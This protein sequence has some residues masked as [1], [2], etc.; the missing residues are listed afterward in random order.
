[1]KTILAPTDFSEISTN[2]VEY[3]V[4]LAKATKAKLILF[5]AYHTPPVALELPIPDMTLAQIEK[6][7]LKRLKDI[8]RGIHQKHGSDLPIHVECSCGFAVDQIHNCIEKHQVDL[9]VLGIDGSSNFMERFI[10]S[11]TT[12][13]MREATC[14]V[15]G[16]SEHCV[17]KGIK[18]IALACDTNQLPNSDTLTPLIEFSKL[19]KSNI[20]I[21]NVVGHALADSSFEKTISTSGLDRSLQQVKHDFHQV[22]NEDVAEGINHFVTEQNMDL[23]VVIPAHHS[24]LDSIFHDPT[25]KR[26]AFHS[27]VPILTLPVKK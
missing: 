15:I 10:G 3:A 23:V 11:I 18:Q 7:C 13:I 19:F 2:S 8:E 16:V 25:T 6:D 26:I 17:F 24:T 1:M 14:P 4:Q 12:A 9:V 22:E 21:L 5:H 27:A 20:H